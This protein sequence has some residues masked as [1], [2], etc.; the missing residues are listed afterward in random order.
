MSPFPWGG[1]GAEKDQSCKRRLVTI[2]S[3]PVGTLVGSKRRLR[4]SEEHGARHA[5]DADGAREKH[6]LDVAMGIEIQ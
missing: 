3:L 4:T 1:G 5:G 6:H 2:N